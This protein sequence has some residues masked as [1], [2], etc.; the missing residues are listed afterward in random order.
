MMSKGHNT[1]KQVLISWVWPPMVFVLFAFFLLLISGNSSAANNLPQQ[2]SVEK[3]TAALPSENS[4]LAE[5][6]EKETTS[7]QQVTVTKVDSVL[8]KKTATTKPT[9]NNVKKNKNDRFTPTEAI[10]EDLAVSFPTD[11]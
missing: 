4:K 6:K 9:I 8:S 1:K 3:N 5:N 10:S 11:I 7:I 2:S